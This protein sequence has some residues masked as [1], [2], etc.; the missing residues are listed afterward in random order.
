MDEAEQIRQYLAKNGATRCPPK[1]ARAP[2]PPKHML[3]A[4]FAMARERQRRREALAT[5]VEVGG[6]SGRHH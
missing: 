3:T 4:R 5:P 2:S 6:N 1:K